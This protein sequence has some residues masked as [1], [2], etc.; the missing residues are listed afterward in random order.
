MTCAPPLLLIRRRNPCTRR[1]Y[2]FLGWK[3]LFMWTAVVYRT[4]ESAIGKAAR[5]LH[6]RY[7]FIEFPKRLAT[8]LGR[9]YNPAPEA[10]QAHS[11]PRSSTGLPPVPRPYPRSGLGLKHTTPLP[12]KTLVGREIS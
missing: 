4:A 10:R 7:H 3:V 12:R 5:A 8:P 6:H 11:S 1:R 9:C 2:R